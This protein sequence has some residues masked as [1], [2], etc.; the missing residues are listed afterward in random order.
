MIWTYIVFVVLLVGM[1]FAFPI[2]TISAIEFYFSG[3]PMFAL[4]TLGIPFVIYVC[5]CEQMDSSCFSPDNYRR[6]KLLLIDLGKIRLVNILTLG[7]YNSLILYFILEPRNNWIGFIPS[8]STMPIINCK[9]YKTLLD[10]PL[11]K[12]NN[13]TKAE[14]KSLYLKRQLMPLILES[15]SANRSKTFRQD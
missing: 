9:Y 8:V 15:L 14:I 6:T 5:T 2:A 4:G 13:W 11:I 10:N 12:K 1:I 3:R 7:L